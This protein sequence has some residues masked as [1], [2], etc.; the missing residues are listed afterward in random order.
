MGILHLAGLGRSPGAVTCGLS[1][2]QRRYGAREKGLGKIV[3]E[4]VVFTS[5]EVASGQLPTHGS[6][7]YNQYGQTR[8]CEKEWSPG[9]VIDVLTQAFE[10]LFPHAVLHV[11]AVDLHDFYD[12]LR[13]VAQTLHYFH[14][15]GKTGHHIQIN[16][17]G[18]TNVLNSALFM[19]ANLSGIVAKFYYTFVQ[20]AHSGF[21][22]PASETDPSQFR[23]QEVPLLTTGARIDEAL[24]YLLT[25]LSELPP[26]TGWIGEDELWS[27]LADV[28]RPA[29]VDRMSFR[30]DYLNVLDGQF[31]RRPGSRDEDGHDTRTS[32]LQLTDEGRKLLAVM[33]S[34]W[35]RALHRDQDLPGAAREELTAGLVLQQKRPL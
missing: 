10:V 22:Q 18:G 15:R 4:V 31:L 32:Q 5:P 21:L 6:V 23:Y 33:E 27:R 2:L 24:H 3:D 9:P 34:S 14:P 28:L 8:C 17:T 13:A 16:L 20:Q 26:E 7:R 19:G 12:C 30:R 25:A 29:G 35:F 1:Y 11:C